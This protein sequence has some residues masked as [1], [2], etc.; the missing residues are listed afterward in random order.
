MC[1]QKLNQGGYDIETIFIVIYT[2][3]KILMEGTSEQSSDLE[4]IKK[5]EDEH[6]RLQRQVGTYTFVVS[7]IYFVYIL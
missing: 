2:N 1:L 3:R 7:I 6:L 5:M 4:V